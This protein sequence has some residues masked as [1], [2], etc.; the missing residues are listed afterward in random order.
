[1]NYY[2]GIGSRKTPEEILYWMGEISGYMAKFDWTLRSGRA[3]GADVAFESLADKKEIYIPWYNFNGCKNGIVMQQD[4]KAT[5]I[6]EKVWNNRYKHN[7]VAVT[8]NSLRG[9]TKLLMTRNCYQILGRNLND[10]SKLVI[11]WTPDGEESGDTGQALWLAKMV[12]ESTNV[13]YRIKIINLKKE[14]HRQAMKNAMKTNLD[15]F[16]LWSYDIDPK[17]GV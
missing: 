8:W 15:P 17:K 7:K 1:M 12:N 3:G 2:A 4:E 10:P 9:P 16:K 14:A 5:A 11:C 6:A 13:H